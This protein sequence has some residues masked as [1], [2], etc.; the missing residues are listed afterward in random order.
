MNGPK[1]LIAGA[2]GAAATRVLEQAQLGEA[3]DVVGL[4]RRRPAEAGD[5]LEA[6]LTDAAGLT[7]A[8][9]KRPD[10]TH[11]VYASRAPHGETG[12]EMSRQMSRCFAICSTLPRPR[13]RISRICT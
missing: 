6:D 9:A 7:R 2:S 12:V 4:S 3:F 10:V 5:W 1:L 13:C 11:I 8:L